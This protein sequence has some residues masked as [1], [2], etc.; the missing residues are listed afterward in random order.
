MDNSSV[1]KLEYAKYMFDLQGYFIV[2]NVLSI[3]EI[4][5]L[6][7]I[8]DKKL[9]KSQGLDF[10]NVDYRGPD[11]GV[12][13]RY[14]GHMFFWL[15]GKEHQYRI[16]NGQGWHGSAENQID[17]SYGFDIDRGYLPDW[18]KNNDDGYVH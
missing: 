3:S 8:L 17:S 18:R 14:I 4:E 7:Q 13:S 9:P 10:R 1:D 16:I 15:S 12:R 11:D 6:N 2:E 5:K